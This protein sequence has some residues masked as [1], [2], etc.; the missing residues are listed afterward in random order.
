MGPAG[1]Y[2][3]AV[4][5]VDGQEG[6]L[7]IGQAQVRSHLH[8][9]NDVVAVGTDQEHWSTK[10]TTLVRKYDTGQK[11]QPVSNSTKLVEKNNT[12]Q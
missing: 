4:D 9:P 10:H 6:V 5:E 7:T 8:E 11:V 2:L 12:G 1:E 3:G